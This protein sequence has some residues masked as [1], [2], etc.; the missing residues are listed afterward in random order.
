MTDSPGTGKSF[1][2][3]CLAQTLGLPRIEFNISQLNDPREVVDC[4]DEIVTMQ[5]RSDTGLLVLSTRLT[6]G[7]V[8]TFTT[9]S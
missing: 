1:L 2:A 7:S 4:F 9:P 8:G 5:L 6:H 3:K